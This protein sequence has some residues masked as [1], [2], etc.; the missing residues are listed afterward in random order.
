M[1]STLLVTRTE[2]DYATRYISTWAEKVISEAEGKGANVI[3]LR[4]KKAIRKEVESRL[5]KNKPSL[6]F[7]NGHGDSECVTGYEEE[8]I[9]KAGENENLLEVGHAFRNK[10]RELA[11]AL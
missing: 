8:V 1:N 7:L 6:V 4:S 3:D 10:T 9:I 5:R 2:D 11:L